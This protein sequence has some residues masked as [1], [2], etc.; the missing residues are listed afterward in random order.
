MQVTCKI[1]T[2]Q[3]GQ[4]PTTLINGTNYLMVCHDQDS[5]EI[6]V[7]YTKNRSEVELIRAFYAI[8][9]YLTNRRLRPIL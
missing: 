2:D 1:L 4:F 6:L 7:E 9:T 8:F 5:N 3:T